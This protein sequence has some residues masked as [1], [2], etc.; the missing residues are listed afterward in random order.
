MKYTLIK[1]V[2]F[3]VAL[4]ASLFGTF[5]LNAQTLAQE[6]LLSKTISVRPNLT[7]ILDDSGSMDL[8]CIYT[9]NTKASFPA[10]NTYGNTSCN[11]SD[12][13][14][15]SPENNTLM[16]DPRK[17][18]DTGYTETGTK[19]PIST[20]TFGQIKTGSIKI[21][22]P[23]Y[24][25]RAIYLFKPGFNVAT[26]TTQAILTNTANYDT[27]WVLDSGNS[28]AVQWAGTAAPTLTTINPLLKPAARSDCV[29]NTTRCTYAEELQNIKNWYTYHSTRIEA[30]KVGVSTAF[31]NLP[32]SFRMNYGSLSE[33]LNSTKGG[34]APIRPVKEYASNVNAFRLWLN[35]NTANLGGTPLREALD[36][37]GKTYQST[38]NSGP[39]GNTPWN[40]GSESASNHVSCRRNFAILTTDGQWNTS[41]SAGYAI[42]T[43]ADDDGKDGSLITH[44]NGTTTYKY[45]AHNT[46]DARSK[47]KAD[48]TSGAGYSQTLSDVAHKYW[49]T[50]LRTLANN[51]T[52]GTPSKPPFWQ[53][54]STYTV[55]FGTSG[56][57]TPTQIA[58]AKAGTANWAQPFENTATA[59]DDLVHAAHNGGGAFIAV[60]DATE[61][62]V[63]LRKILL[64][65]TGETSSQAGVAASTTALQTGTKKYVPYYVTGEWWGNVKSVNLD[66]QTAA[67]TTIAWQV[68]A[69]DTEGRPTGASTIPSPATRN[70]I[71]S[72]N[73][74]LKGVD[75]TFTNLGTNGLIA[76]TATA[77]S[78]QVI[79]TFNTDQVDY[80][81]GVRTKEGAG[82]AYRERLA[83][84]GDIVNSRPAF[85]KNNTDP[86][87]L[88]F[89]LPTTQGGGAAYT[90]YKADKAARTDGV[91][92]VGA[93]DGMLHGFRESDGKEMLGFIPRSVLGAL[94]KLT[95]KNYPISHQFYVDG[96]IKEAD[97]Y[98]SAPYLN[99]AAGSSVRWT[100][101]IVG[102]T[103]A[104]AK[105]VFAIDVTK[106]SSMTS[107]Q[108]KHV[109]WEVSN[110][111]S[112]FTELGNVLADVE[113]GV[114]PSGDWVAAF[115]NGYDSLSGKA[116]LFLVNLSTGAKI[117]EL[118]AGPTITANGLGGVRLVRNANSEV[119]GAYAGDLKGNVWRFD[120]TGTNSS[121][122]KNGELLYTA[123]GPTGQ[124][125][126]ITAAPAVF[127]RNDGKPGYIVVVGTG[128]L[129]TVADTVL[130]P[131]PPTQ[132]S[133]GLWD[134]KPFGTATTISTIAGRSAL[135]GTTSTADAATG[136]YNVSNV[137]PI[138]WN[139]DKGWYLDYTQLIGQR[140]IYPITALKTLVSI[141]TIAPKAS[142]NSCSIDGEVKAVN[143]LLS[144]YT[145]ACKT[146]TQTLDTNNDQTVSS[147]DG[148]A[149]AYSSF[150]DGSNTIIDKTPD[151]V[152]PGGPPGGT[153][154]GTPPGPPPPETCDDRRLK[155]SLGAVDNQ[156]FKDCDNSSPTKS[157][158]QRDV[159]QI[160]IRK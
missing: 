69:T 149:C 77:V 151:V 43:T 155:I 114:T 28:F 102:T 133:Y 99:G 144:P 85:V 95:D 17:V 39:W 118:T 108:G 113:T 83:I 24:Q 75:F 78:N 33:I 48:K 9:Q 160:F 40:P 71:V 117:R 57:M 84:L 87:W 54:L 4:I 107:I 15:T 100:N 8:D 154:D 61:F 76:P 36:I 112:G 145:G 88:Y 12:L 143:F 50:D 156:F 38:A 34:G 150:G 72:T 86:Y 47:G 116:S 73:N 134:E 121:N 10:G 26:A 35:N 79:N 53:N 136:Y 130:S 152:P 58:N 25:G 62:S 52:D 135:V 96:P 132:S 146:N 141:E 125:Q 106:P 49:V 13:R 104:G 66:V 18:Y 20:A 6:P 11:V 103:G 147:T 80:I 148:Y 21:G 70:I 74:A 55:G 27:F 137:R 157:S 42:S 2:L 142:T 65:I 16:Y 105:A 45:I 44:L 31:T 32:D 129:L 81:R 153:P 158:F 37:V 115:G 22:S 138:N 82:Q 120:L 7:F 97:A 98:I 5:S 63:E 14:Y 56:S 67:D 19:R 51:V 1:P 90:A 41:A 126:P 46:S 60:N 59:V 109:M 23:T 131:T 101:L 68:V 91:L 29:L 30:A 94:H 123:L 3:G 92:F 159:R 124:T 64:S 139:T 89:K 128:K 110:S 93:N 140:A 111:S 127:A 119:I 122:W